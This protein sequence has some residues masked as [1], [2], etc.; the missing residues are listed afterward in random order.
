MASEVAAWDNHKSVTYF[1][2]V[3]VFVCT[4]TI[5]IIFV[6]LFRLMQK[7]TIKETCVSPIYWLGI[8][9]SNRSG[10]G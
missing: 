4:I 6:H 5:N 2:G 3:S 1:K 8:T 9:M 7:T 10:K